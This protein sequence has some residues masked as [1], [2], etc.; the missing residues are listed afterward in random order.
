MTDLNKIE[1]SKLA[2]ETGNTD[3]SG[4][5]STPNAKDQWNSI[6]F[7]KAEKEVIRLQR[8]IAKAQQEGR[9]NKVKCLQYIL[10]RS[11]YAHLIAVKRVSS[12]KGSKT[13]GVDGQLWRSP[14]R[15]WNAAQTIKRSINKYQYRAKPLRRIYIPKKNNKKRPLGIPTL[16]DRAVQALHALTL[17]PVAETLADP[18]SYGFRRF[19]CTADAIEQCFILL[20]R[21][22]SAQ[23]VLEADIKAC[24]DKIDHPWMTEHIPMDKHALNQWLKSGYVDKN[25]LFPTVEGT[26]Q[27][28]IISPILCNMALDGLEQRIKSVCP[29]RDQKVSF[30]RYAD[31]F[32]VTCADKELIETHIKPA[33]EEFLRPRGLTLS[34]EKTKITHI[35]EGFDFLGQNVRKYPN[36]K[37]IIKPSKDSI[38]GLLDKVRTICRES[39]GH[40]A[41]ILINRLNPV[42]RGWANYHRHIASKST[43]AGVDYQ[44]NQAIVRWIKRTHPKKS[45]KWINRKYYHRITP[46][47]GAVFT[48]KVKPNKARKDNGK[49]AEPGKTRMI[50]LYRAASTK[51]VRR[52]KVRMNANP[53]DPGQTSYFAMRKKSKGIRENGKSWKQNR[54]DRPSLKT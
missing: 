48:A 17:E 32:I 18:N 21:K 39:R 23:W 50:S 1:E 38:K 10:S 40:N 3:S 37:L 8:R 52:V 19:R 33:I 14:S 24:Y 9:I 46:M 53:F 22:H 7:K 28:G 30:V 49:T 31:D 45:W 44:V 11:H 42:I 51:I 43:F 47:N 27:G 13:P 5:T 16:F 36:G 26:P 29:K 12:S 15:K 35:T 20:S 25:Q 34:K 2:E 4:A 54:R 41:E 6:D